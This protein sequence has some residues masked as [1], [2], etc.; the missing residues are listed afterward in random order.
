MNLTSN[1]PSRPK[2]RVHH[3]K[4][5]AASRRWAVIGLVVAGWLGAAPIA[6]LAAEPGSKSQAGKATVE[7]ILRT[8]VKISSHVPDTART[9]RSLGTERE[10]SGVVIRANGLIL[11][12]GYIILEAA[13]IDVTD[14][15]GRRFGAEFVAYDHR[16]GFGLIRV[17][18]GL[19]LEPLKFGDSAAVAE[20]QV[21]MVA[22]HGGAKSAIPAVVV[23]RRAFA[24][25]WEYLL[26]R[27]IFTAPPHFDWG[28]AAL[29]DADGKLVG[30]GSLAVGDAVKDQAVPGNMF[31]PINLL[32]PILKDLVAT[33]R[34]SAKS[35]PWLGMHTEEI[36]GRL[37]VTRTPS[38][39]PARAAGIRPGD[40]VLAIG[41]KPVTSM[42][43]LYRKIWALGDAGVDVP[44]KVLQGADIRDITVHSSDRYKFLNLRPTY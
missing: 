3:R 24:G 6:A 42:V 21:V 30:V 4:R 29:I 28:G 34:S 32:R 12:I 7:R 39:G 8:I 14:H 38:R 27:A 15:R 41:G 16:S 1:V 31:V 36:R 20:K 13:T 26:D 44:V 9:S 17:L 2:P 19:D 43:D 37:F 18:R 40:I 10:G 5:T 23:S 11:T 33:G 25:S 35:K 22:S